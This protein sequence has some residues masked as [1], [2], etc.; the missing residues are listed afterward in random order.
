MCRRATVGDSNVGKS[1]LLLRF[2]EDKYEEDY[3]STIGVDFVRLPFPR[4]P[5]A[6]GWQCWLELIIQAGR[7]PRKPPRH[8]SSAL[9]RTERPR[10]PRK[11]VRSKSMAPRSSFSW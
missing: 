7:T 6:R 11:T 8:P 3:L 2:S 1:C 9:T 5:A 10:A 4:H